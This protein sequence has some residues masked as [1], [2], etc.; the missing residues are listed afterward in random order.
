M[1]TK[2]RSSESGVRQ[3]QRNI[4]RA[5]DLLV[6]GKLNHASQLGSSSRSLSTPKSLCL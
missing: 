5:G 4:A 6:K 1:V 3:V 2:E